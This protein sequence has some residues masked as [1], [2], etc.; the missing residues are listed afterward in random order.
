VVTDEGWVDALLLQ[1]LAHQ[2]VQQAGR[3]LR[4]WAVDVVLGTQVNLH[5]P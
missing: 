4:G 1:E 2:L 3:G 5:I